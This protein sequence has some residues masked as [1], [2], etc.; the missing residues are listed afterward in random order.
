MLVDFEKRNVDGEADEEELLLLLQPDQLHL[1]LPLRALVLHQKALAA[2]VAAQRILRPLGGNGRAGAPE[3][4]LELVQQSQ[5]YE[6]AVLR[7]AREKPSEL[8]NLPPQK[9]SP[10]TFL[11]LL[12]CQSKRAHV[13][14]VCAD[15]LAGPSQHQYTLHSN[16]HQWHVIG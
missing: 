9:L 12:S 11:T 16:C 15:L 14:T 4:F 5:R 8:K 6:A 3:G 1:Q 7:G 2:V 10:N 13:T